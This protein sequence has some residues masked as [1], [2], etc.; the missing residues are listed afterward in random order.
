MSY[1]GF[2]NIVY[3]VPTKSSSSFIPDSVLTFSVPIEQM[4]ADAVAIAWPNVMARIQNELPGLVQ[5]AWPTVVNSA[6]ASMPTFVD[7]ALPNVSARMPQI[8]DAALPSV[9]ARMPDIAAQAVN[10][11]VLDPVWP[12]LQK[13]IDASVPAAWNQVAPLV[14]KEVKDTI[15]AEKTNA[16]A[17]AAL[18]LGIL[19][20]AGYVGYKRL[21]AGHR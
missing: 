17:L 19:L 2:G 21:E 18:G 15:A 20:T 6:S 11:A 12:E 13:R 14:R 16:L 3:N 9:Y 5:Q 4:T 8:V 7:A 1:S 10:P